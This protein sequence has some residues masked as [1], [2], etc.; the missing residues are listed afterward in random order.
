MCRRSALK[1][2]SNGPL[3]LLAGRYDGPRAASREI[4]DS[5]RS[6]LVL[7]AGFVSTSRVVPRA[8]T[9][10]LR[11]TSRMVNPNGEEGVDKTMMSKF[12]NN[13]KTA[14]LLGLLTALILW[15]GLM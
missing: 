1:T 12:Y 6:A 8:R 4:R 15:A 13:A 11:L 3:P 14:V 9:Y 10:Y 2:A 5:L 7:N